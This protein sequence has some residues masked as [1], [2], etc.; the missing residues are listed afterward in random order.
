MV[1][2]FFGSEIRNKNFQKEVLFWEVFG[3]QKVRKK[4]G[5][6]NRQIYTIWFSFYVPTKL[7]KKEEEK[8]K[9]PKP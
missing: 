5:N 8:G 2:Y 1:G 7:K 4:Q 9:T 3:R 6:K